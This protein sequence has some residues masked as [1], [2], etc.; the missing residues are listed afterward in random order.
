MEMPRLTPEHEALSMLV[1]SW[2][3]AER[4]HPSGFDPVGGEAIGRVHN[5]LALDGFAVIQDYE[6]ERNGSVNF[7]GHAVFRWDSGEKCYVLHW[8]DSFGGAPAKYRGHLQ[9]R[10]LTFVGTTSGGYAR[11]IFD[12]NAQESYRYSLSISP[13]GQ[14]WVVFTEGEYAR[15]TA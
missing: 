11:A 3:G 8:F 15:L 4:I 13:D 6:Q 5:R 2:Q 9:G 14:E 7:R 10:V 1:G 12:F